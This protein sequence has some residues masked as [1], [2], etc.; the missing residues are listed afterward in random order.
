MDKNPN[1][2]LV[3]NKILDALSAKKQ[4]LSYEDYAELCTSKQFADQLRHIK[5]ALGIETKFFNKSHYLIHQ[6]AYRVNYKV[7]PS[8]RGTY[9]DAHS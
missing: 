3:R 6:A 1:L 9:A 5:D 7:S 4:V 2:C 8:R